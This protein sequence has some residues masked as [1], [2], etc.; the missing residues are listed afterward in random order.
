MQTKLKPFLL[1][2]ALLGTLFASQNTQAEEI[3]CSGPVVGY[4]K[5]ICLEQETQ[6]SILSDKK[7]AAPV[8][9]SDI[10]KNRYKDAIKYVQENNIV[11]GYQDKT[12]RPDAPLNR[13]EFTKI[14]IK[15]KLNGDPAD[16]TEPCFPDV[17]SGVW[18]EKY[19]CYAK[20]NKILGGYPDGTFG[21]INDVNFAE[22]SKII[23]NTFG[24]TPAEVPQDQPWY[25][26]FIEALAQKKNIP[27]TISKHNHLL[28][29][30]EMAEMIKRIMTNDVNQSSL[31]T[32]DLIETSCSENSAGFGDQFLVGVDMKQVRAEWIKWLNTEREKLGL[33]SYV[34]NN[35]LNRSAYLWSDEMKTRG[36]VSHKRV[37]QTDFYDYNLIKG[38]FNNLN[39]DFENVNTV[40]FSENIGAGPFDC[41][42]GD[43]TQALTT[44]IKSTFD[45]YM[46][47][48]GTAD[49][50]HYNSV[51][52]KY[53]QEIGLGIAVD[54]DAKKYFLTVHYGTSLK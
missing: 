12:Y 37:G 40:T 43:C 19:V 28:T 3:D 14:L 45:A 32:C 47:E 11:S 35:Q 46:A 22:A 9:F 30:G 4:Q 25:T 21:P 20:T 42:S 33:Q 2:F 8:E 7:T 39:L 15:A 5:R 6:A 38:W 48:K 41:S 29:R 16:P 26:A 34:Y 49:S 51:M 52:N 10:E 17:E 1:T 27:G 13:A 54:K 24:I 36:M 31:S 23:V 50:A 18:F 44:A 53:F